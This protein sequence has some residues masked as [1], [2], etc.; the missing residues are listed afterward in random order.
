LQLIPPDD[1]LLLRKELFWQKSSNDTTEQITC[2]RSF[3]LPVEFGRLLSLIKIFLR[4]LTFDQRFLLVAEGA[5][6]WPSW[7][8]L[9]LYGMMKKSRGIEDL[10]QRGE[11]LLFIRDELEDVTSFTAIVAL[12]RWDFRLL[13]SSI[14]VLLSCS[15]DDDCLVRVPKSKEQM[16]DNLIARILHSV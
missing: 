15:H 4:E 1:M 10:F 14:G 12:F 3:D 5:G 9:N 11:G 6:I 7:Q 16:L 8:D 13:G 2:E